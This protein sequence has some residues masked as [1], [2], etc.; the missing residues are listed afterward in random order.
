MKGSHNILT[1]KRF[2]PTACVFTDILLVFPAKPKQKSAA[3]NWNKLPAKP[4]TANIMQYEKAATAVTF[5]L[6]NFDT[7]MPATGSERK[8]PADKAKSTMPNCV[9]V[10]DSFC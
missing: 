1:I 5:L 9:S 3:I 10:S 2:Y 7:N 4:I 8:E 6:P